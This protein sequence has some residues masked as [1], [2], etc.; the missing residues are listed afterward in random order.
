MF[1]PRPKP[2]MNNAL[3]RLAQMDAQMHIDD[4]TPIAP[5]NLFLSLGPRLGTSGSI[6]VLPP[7]VPSERSLAAEEKKKKR[8]NK[9]KPQKK[10]KK[11][12]QSESEEEEEESSS[13]SEGRGNS[14]YDDDDDVSPDS[15]DDM[16]V[17]THSYGKPIAMTQQQQA[18]P[19]THAPRKKK[20]LHTPLPIDADTFNYETIMR[21]L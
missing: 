7:L 20:Y 16:L 19:P 13:E 1:T 9:K 18:P 3:S 21:R 12:A 6:N 11:R 2:N 17:V 14:D 5:P 10:K 8:N 15:I 4:N